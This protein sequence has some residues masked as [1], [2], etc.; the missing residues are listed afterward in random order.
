MLRLSILVAQ[1]ARP[2]GEQHSPVRSWGSWGTGKDNAMEVR[3]DRRT[4]RDSAG[5]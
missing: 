4:K 3:I 5:S 2:S 1:K